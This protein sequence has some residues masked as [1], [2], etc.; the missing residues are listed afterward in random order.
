MNEEV[1]NVSMCK[2]LK[3]VILGGEVWIGIRIEHQPRH[4]FGSDHCL[5]LRLVPI[6]VDGLLVS[7]VSEV[8]GFLLQTVLGVVAGR[9]R[10]FALADH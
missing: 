3:K 7:A 4:Q 2:F 1:F 6:N 9:C 8:S 5:I 10:M